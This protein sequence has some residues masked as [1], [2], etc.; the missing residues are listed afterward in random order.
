MIKKSLSAYAFSILMT[1]GLFSCNDHDEKAKASEEIETDP[2]TF[3]KEGEAYVIKQ[4]G[5]TISQLD[6]EFA[7]SDYEHQTGL[8]Y[9]ES[10]DQD[11]GMIFIYTSERQ[12]NF[13]MKNT[14]IPLD[15]LYFDA[16]T[17]FVSAQ[18][19]AVPRD[20]TSLPSDGPAQYILE[21][22]AG[23]NND[24]NLAEGDRI[25]FYKTDQ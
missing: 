6:V 11:Q 13:Y 2:I 4:N 20:E 23:L 17:L 24:W 8:M 12:R 14:Y 25:S 15:I 7:E 3:T 19:N 22:N 16:D 9:R 21:V 18:E 10:M 1:A 5:D